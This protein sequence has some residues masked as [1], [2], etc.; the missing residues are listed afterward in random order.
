MRSLL[1][2]AQSKNEGSINLCIF[3]PEQFSHRK[4]VTIPITHRK[5][6]IK[7]HPVVV[8]V[9]LLLLLL[10]MLFLFFLLM[11]VVVVLVLVEHIGKI[12]RL[13]PQQTLRTLI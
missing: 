11:V 1:I 7:R 13:E 12:H 9:V 8:L 3:L 5:S 6:Q 2:C 4:F 10:L